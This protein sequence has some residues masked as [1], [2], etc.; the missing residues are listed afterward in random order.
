MLSLGLSDSQIGF[1]ATVYM[2]SQVLFAFLSGPITDKMGRRKATAVFDFIA[3]SIPCIIWWRAVSFE[4]FL[5]AAVLNG[6][7]RVTTC[8]WECLLVEDAES[9]QITGLY[10]LIVAIGQI[11]GL[12]APISSILISRFTLIPAMRILYVNAF[13]LMTL[14]IVILYIFSH[15]TKRGMIRLGETRGQ[16]IL[17]LAA[18]YG[19]I[20]KLIFKSPGTLFA[21][22]VTILSGIVLMLN[23]TFWQIIVNRKL[24]VSESLLPFFTTLKSVVAI[25]FLF[26]LAPRLSKGFFKTALLLSFAFYFFGQALLILTPSTGTIRYFTICLSLVFDSFGSCSL[27]M[28]ASS[29]VALNANPEERAR[30]MAVLQMITMAV[31]APFGWIGGMLSEISRALPFVLNLFLL[32]AGFGITAV[33]HKRTA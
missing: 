4:Y 13:T 2:L 25:I 23:S 32:A 7:M 16:S 9:S 14:K 10:S 12:V 3:W 33:F 21:L 20:V 31:S 30:V 26:L 29:L 1:V 15:E 17:S 5:A 19:G 24:L 6:A 18:G 27:F 28:F 8:S 22:A 11:G